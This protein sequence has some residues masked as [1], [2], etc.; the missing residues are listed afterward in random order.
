MEQIS[1]INS[2]VP[3]PPPPVNTSVDIEKVEK[4]LANKG[5]VIQ[6]GTPP[7][8]NI[9]RF[10]EKLKETLTSN[11]PA[12][13][14]VSIIISGALEVEFGRSFT[15]SRNFDKIVRKVADTVVTNP[16]LRRQALAVAS[17]FLEKKM[18]AGK[19]N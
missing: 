4:E 1:E 9:Q 5:M 6:T 12:K 15:L 8:D 11:L 17:I 10:Q 18:H 3:S 16:D 2:A 7:V 19:K 13:E 14:L